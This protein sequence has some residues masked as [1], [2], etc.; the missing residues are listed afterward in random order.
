M[1][2]EA[3][4]L[5]AEADDLHALLSQLTEAQ[6][7]APTP[8]KGWTPFD[9]VAHLHASDRVALLSIEDSAAFV[10]MAQGRAA[11]GKRSPFAVKLPRDSVE[12]K[13]GA[14]LL[15]Q[16]SQLLQRL[17]DRLD[18]ADPSARLKWFGP[19]MGV[20]M[21]A[22]ARQMETWAHAQDVYD[23]LQR[24]RVYTDRIKSICVIGVRTFGWTFAN[25]K[26]QPPGAPPYVRLEAPSGEV[27]EWNDVDADNS[28][29]GTASDFCHVVTQNR[30][31]ADAQLV[32]TGEVAK[33]W[34]AIAQCFA[35]PPVDPPPPGTRC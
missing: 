30:N 5:R 32:V 34:M 27:W 1:L 26:Q 21:F 23:L 33:Q 29:Q 35:G 20:R 12:T 22:T 19:D 11:D 13:D 9:V 6:W 18:V 15:Q 3:Q 14:T 2:Q 8:F 10:A 7:W 31:V 28:V 25:R 16:W 17:C 4:D 24:K